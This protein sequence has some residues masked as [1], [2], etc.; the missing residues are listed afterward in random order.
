[1]HWWWLMCFFKFTIS[2]DSHS[3]GARTTTWTCATYQIFSVQCAIVT[4]LTTVKPICIWF[5]NSDR[6]STS[7][8][9]ILISSFDSTG[10]YINFIV[11]YFFP[12]FSIPTVRPFCWTT[13]SAQHFVSNWKVFDFGW[14]KKI[15][16]F[17]I[18]LPCVVFSFHNIHSI[19]VFA[20]E[21]GVGSGRY[22]L[23]YIACDT[24]SHSAKLDYNNCVNK[25][26][27]CRIGMSQSVIK[28]IY[29]CTVCL[30]CIRKAKW[31]I[32]KNSEI[33]WGLI[34]VVVAVVVVDIT[35]Q[36]IVFALILLRSN[37]I[38]YVRYYL[39]LICTESPTLAH[40]RWTLNS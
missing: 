37:G 6:A 1:M 13:L 34:V 8:A 19:F 5:L 26:N 4:V 7:S 33:F 32:R 29:L 27:S 22:S 20:V 28:W 17:I 16:H 14:R 21:R 23:I 35:V 3:I 11:V 24:F 38:F 30:L 15:H 10:R 12:P 18:C 31:K 9:N 36:V 39:F 40:N 25:V 2:R